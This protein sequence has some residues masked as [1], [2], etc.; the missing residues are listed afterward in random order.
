MRRGRERGRGRERETERDRER[1]RRESMDEK[2]PYI[3]SRLLTITYTVLC[4]CSTIVHST[5]HIWTHF[6]LKIFMLCHRE[7]EGVHIV[8]TVTSAHHIL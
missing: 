1:D 3:A 5:A 6:L 2:Y 8:Y 7:E 4:T